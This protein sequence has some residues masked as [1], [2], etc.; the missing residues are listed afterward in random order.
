[1]IG[2]V[3]TGQEMVRENKI[4]IIDLFSCSPRSNGTTSTQINSTT[5]GNMV[6]KMKRANW[7]TIWTYAAEVEECRAVE[8]AEG[9]G[10]EELL[11][12]GTL[13]QNEAVSEEAR[14]IFYIR[15]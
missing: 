2:W 14:V 1:M 3:T 7:E 8:R 13:F 4:H 10:A 12:V 9:P 6:T 11:Y 15:E 5:E